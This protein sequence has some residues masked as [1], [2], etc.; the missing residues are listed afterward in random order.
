MRGVDTHTLGERPAKKNVLIELGYLSNKHDRELLN[1][2][3]G[4]LLF[5]QAIAQYFKDQV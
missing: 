2:R 4:Q 3:E 5:A 1:S